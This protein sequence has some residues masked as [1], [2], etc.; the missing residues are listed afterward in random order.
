[1]DKIT[2]LTPVHIATGIDIEMPSYHEMNDNMV[3][4]YD[5][6]DILSQLPPNILTDPRILNELSSKQSSKKTLYKYIHQYVDYSKLKPLY[7]LDYTYDESL[8]YA[9]TD[10]SEQVHDLHKPYIPGSTI[11][12]TLINAWMYFLLKCNYQKHVKSNIKL[13]LDQDSKN[14]LG[15][16]E[17]IFRKQLEKEYSDFYKDLCGCLQCRDLYF[18]KME[19]FYAAREGSN[20]DMRGNVP[21]TYKECIPPFE[22]L[23]SELFVVDQFKLN[24]LKQK[25]SKCEQYSNLDFL[26]HSFTRKTLFKACN[27]FMKDILE[28]DMQN[29]YFYFYEDFEGIN[30]SLKAIKQEIAKPNTVILRVGNSTNYFAKTV[31]YLIK[32]NDPE[33]F[34]KN[35]YD[36]FAPVNYGK[37]KPNEKTM[38]KTRVIYSNGEK[39]YLPG[40]IKVEYDSES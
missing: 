19:L 21:M 29:R 6:M 18:D 16:H 32:K 1:M 37:T 40:F 30:E 3:A 5:F 22:K 8:N 24:L 39:D 7:Y 12:G 26:I 31:S 9:R 13:I 2:I 14:S 17:L 34:E 35:F 23:D 20:R 28:V 11:K 36:K 10:V 4:R 33:L 38:P 15:F 25:Y 27:S